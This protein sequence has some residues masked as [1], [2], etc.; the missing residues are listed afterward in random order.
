MIKIAINAIYA[1][2]ELELNELNFFFR[3]E[4]ILFV[5]LFICCV[6]CWPFFLEFFPVTLALLP[7]FRCLCAVCLCFYFQTSSLLC[8]CI[9]LHRTHHIFFSLI[10][11]DYCSIFCKQSAISNEKKNCIYLIAHTSIKIKPKKY[12]YHSIGMNA[13]AIYR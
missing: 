6:L 5:Y 7:T 3:S 9:G 2:R 13:R 12:H 10:K 1:R 8:V 4:W 11:T